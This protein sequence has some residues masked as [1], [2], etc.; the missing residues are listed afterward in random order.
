MA[1]QNR[2]RARQGEAFWRAHHEA[3]KR[4]ELN[5]VVLRGGADSTQARQLAFAVQSRATGARAQADRTRVAPQ[6]LR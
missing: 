3:W 2:L 1:D 6:V 4:S 5:V